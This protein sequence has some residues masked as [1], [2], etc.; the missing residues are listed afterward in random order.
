M[1]ETKVNLSIILKGRVMYSEQEAKAQNAYDTFN[2]QVSEAKGEN[3]ETI[4]VSTRQ[5][6]PI[7]QSINLTKEAYLWMISEV[8]FA[9]AK[10]KAGHWKAM[11]PKQRLETHLRKITENLGGEGFSYS[12]LED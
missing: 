12:I 9:D 11:T 2:M 7:K 8:S 3:K 4:T 6:K 5:L 10:V 1:S